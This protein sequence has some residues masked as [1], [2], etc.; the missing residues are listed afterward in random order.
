MGTKAASSALVPVALAMVGAFFLSCASVLVRAGIQ[1]TNAIVALFFTLLVNIIVLWTASS[2]LY[3][4]V[5][6][7]WQ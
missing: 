3:E 7:L 4:I 5:F 6:D 1:H 2:L